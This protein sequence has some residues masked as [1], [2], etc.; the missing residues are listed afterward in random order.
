LRDLPERYFDLMSEGSQLAKQGQFSEAVQRFADA[1]TEGNSILRRLLELPK[2]SH[3][4]SW[5]LITALWAFKLLKS[6]FY[7]FLAQ[8]QTAKTSAQHQNL[9]LAAAG[10]QHVGHDMIAAFEA[11]DETLAGTDREL[12]PLFAEAIRNFEDRQRLLNQQLEGIDPDLARLLRSPGKK[13]P[14]KPSKNAD[15]KP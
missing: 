9:L 12:L 2:S 13:H 14:V 1:R 8:S 7:W 6:V 4:T 15:P 11:L 5:Q 10:A 3:A